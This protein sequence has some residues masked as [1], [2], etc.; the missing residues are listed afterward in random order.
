MIIS[1]QTSKHTGKKLSHFEDEL[2][3]KLDNLLLLECVVIVFDDG[4]K[5]KLAQDWRGNE[6]YFSQ[7]EIHAV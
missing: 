6:C 7:Y 2:G 1:E 5:I 3:Q 4:T